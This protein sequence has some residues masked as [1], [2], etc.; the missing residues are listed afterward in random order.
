MR[1][2]RKLCA[3]LLSGLL[4]F[5]PAAAFAVEVRA[6][7]SFKK[8]AGAWPAFM[9]GPGG[10][11][12]SL[13]LK[14]L[15][16]LDQTRF[17]LV[18]DRTLL[19]PEELLQAGS[20]E[21]QA[22]L[23]RAHLKLHASWLIEFS[24]PGKSPQ[25]V[26]SLE[27]LG[28]EIADLLSLPALLEKSLREPLALA[29]RS[30]SGLIAAEKIRQALTRIEEAKL[31]WDQAPP[32]DPELW[33]QLD[34]SAAGSVRQTSLKELMQHTIDG[35]IMD[36]EN[37]K[38]SPRLSPL[39]W[40]VAS[41]LLDRR[42]RHLEKFGLGLHRTSDPLG[43]MTSGKPLSP[44]HRALL[45]AA[46][47]YSP[48]IDPAMAAVHNDIFEAPG[49]AG[50]ANH[51]AEPEA[52]GFIAI[53]TRDRLELIQTI[54]HE[55]F[56]Q[57][58]EPYA[59]GGA[60]LKMLLQ[61]DKGSDNLWIA[62]LEGYTE[63]RARQA[64]LRILADGFAGKSPFAVSVVDLVK[65]RFRVSDLASAQRSLR[66][67]WDSHYYMPYVRLTQTLMDELGG[68]EAVDLLV[69]RGDISLFASRLGPSR[70][71]LLAHLATLKDKDLSFG[72]GKT[73]EAH[74]RQSSKINKL[75]TL[76]MEQVVRGQLTR[77]RDVHVLKTLLWEFVRQARAAL[78][79]A[80]PHAQR[81]YL[82]AFLESLDLEDYLPAK[83]WHAE[84][85]ALRDDIKA[86]MADQ[87]FLAR[88][89]LTWKEAGLGAL[90]AISG[91][92]VANGLFLHG[93]PLPFPFPI[94]V[95]LAT[96]AGLLAAH[97]A[98]VLELLRAPNRVL[99]RLSDY[100][101]RY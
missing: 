53:A 99:Q 84:R 29:R 31:E 57:G 58:D 35:R 100:I 6:A 16:V 24:A 15:G 23:L 62:L 11:P 47:E 30:V 96:A 64:M 44:R 14:S 68:P 43:Y 13:L 27:A 83:K 75:I 54:L 26:A 21:K 39:Q 63:W 17:A 42:I 22:A 55:G 66:T 73:A 56:H 78:A 10:A 8:A 88:F 45:E 89:G 41:L 95:V 33:A 51:V 38:S 71:G 81:R 92:F 25:G 76:R 80:S 70:L 36:L 101:S 9:K 46:K 52:K 82:D 98:S 1:P 19:A 28:A 49:A 79:G 50:W 18:M 7:A 67:W 93:P 94:Q 59:R 37:A 91:V 87:G 61:G 60:A 5:Q 77:H 86:V 97:L 85:E 72:G 40:P 65:S 2:L 74:I 3:A 32:V 90:T 34:A 48:G 4:A 12:A 20:P 69:A